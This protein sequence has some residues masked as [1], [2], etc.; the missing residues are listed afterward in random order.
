MQNRHDLDL[1]QLEGFAAVARHRSVTAAARELGLSQPALTRQI[2]RLQR[3]LGIALLAK[4]GR[5]IRITAAGQRF[6]IWSEGTLERYQSM[7][8]ELKGVATSIAGNLRVAASTSPG[9]FLVPGLVSGFTA[10]HP[11]VRPEVMIRDSAGVI[12]L[13]RSYEADVGF[14]GMRVPGNDLHYQ[15]I[16]EDEILLAV[17]ADHPFSARFEVELADL[18]GEPFLER[19]VGSGTRSTFEAALR[20]QRLPRPGYRVAMVLGNTEAVVSAVQDGY[21]M[22]LVS[23]L[24]IRARTPGR[25]VTVRLRGLS[26]RRS[27]FMVQCATR[28]LPVSVG[29]FIEWVGEQRS[30]L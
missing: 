23:S 30:G 3:Q 10:V 15:T 25:L 5:S 7:R 16:G 19:E 22:G 27:L 21:G 24:A 8:D 4:E 1:D 28:D 9:E 18:A 14:V 29:R 20:E 2:Q 17:P 13:L 11:L 6:L 12:A 26:L